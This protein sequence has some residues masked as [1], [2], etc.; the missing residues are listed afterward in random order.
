M[1][2][3][4][5]NRFTRSTV[6]RTWKGKR[7]LDLM[8][9]V[10]KEHDALLVGVEK[11]ERIVVNPSEYVFDGGEDVVLIASGPVRL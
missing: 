2:H 5:G 7:F 11:D 10:K 8:L 6:P 3:E 4:Q 1:T 9:H